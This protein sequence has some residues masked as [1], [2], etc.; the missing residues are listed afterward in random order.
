MERRE[1]ERERKKEREREVKN[2]NKR[3]NGDKKINKDNN[4]LLFTQVSQRMINRNTGR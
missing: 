3:K 2:N 1:R 4:K